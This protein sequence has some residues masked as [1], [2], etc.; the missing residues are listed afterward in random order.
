MSPGAKD[1]QLRAFPRLD[2]WIPAIYVLVSA[3]WI[4]VSDLLLA[5]ASLPA[6][7]WMPWAIIKGVGF[8]VLT[9]VGL[10]AILRWALTRQRQAHRMVQA[11]EARYR[12]FFENLRELVVV[13]EAVPDE[14]GVLGWKFSEANRSAL[15]CLG[16]TLGDQQGGAA[17]AQA[18]ERA[19]AFITERWAAVL[20]TGEPFSGEMTIEG[21]VYLLSVF[22]VDERAVASAAIDITERKRAEDALRDSNEQKSHFFAMLS[23]EL[24]NPLAPMRNA[25]WLMDRTTPGS[26]LAVRA[27]DTLSR[28]VLHLTRI[29]EALLDMN[30]I[31]HGR[32]LLQK[33][34]TDLVSLVQRALQ[35]HEPQFASREVSLVADLTSL[36]IWIEGDHTR[37]Q[38]AVGNLLDNAARFSEPGGNTRVTVERVAGGEA[39][40]RVCDDGIG[41]PPLVLS[42][43]FEPFVQADTGLHRARGGLGLGLSLVKALVELHGG[44]VQVA[45]DGPG[46][47]SEFAIRLPLAHEQPPVLDH[48]RPAREAMPRHRVLVVEDQPDAADTL[49]EMLLMWDHE[50]EVAH[51]GREGIEK[52]CAWRPDIVLCDIGLP[53]MDGYSVARAIRASPEVSSAYLVAI[54]GY[55]SADDQREALNAGFDRHL[56][57][58]V[59]VE[60]LEDVLTSVVGVAVTHH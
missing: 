40:V 6:S 44:T 29:T 8:V 31:S 17:R 20:A 12:A 46:R 53:V 21:S 37:L 33:D 41:I 1:L 30:R 45:S 36:P 26:E 51:D 50:V 14:R 32:I 35:D 25:L 27:R 5:R 9:A 57:K 16:P 59:P 10:H 47:G 4:A 55:A 13:F 42:R 24:R 38:Q 34:R 48:H 60:T 39:V 15:E 58:P 3:A 19:R 54:T 56:G 43:V 11:S 28:Q 23:H 7:T 22:R 49:R 52:A 18:A 2:L